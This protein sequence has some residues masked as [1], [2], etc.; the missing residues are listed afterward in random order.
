MPFPVTEDM[1]VAA[2]KTAD[3]IGRA[4]KGLDD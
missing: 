3:K 1:V 4:Y 2:I